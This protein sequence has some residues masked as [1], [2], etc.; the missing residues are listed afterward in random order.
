MSDTTHPD[1]YRVEG[2]GTM[3]ERDVIDRSAKHGARSGERSDEEER[4]EHDDTV[5][6]QT[7]FNPEEGDDVERW[8]E[9]ADRHHERYS[10]TKNSRRQRE[11]VYDAK[12]VASQLEF[13]DYQTEELVRRLTSVDFD[14]H[15]TYTYEAVILA[16]STLVANRDGRWLRRNDDDVGD[17]LA[18]TFEKLR[19]EFDVRRGTIRRLRKRLRP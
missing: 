14:E 3:H 12:L 2:E 7:T 16:L 18:A 17:D 19:R 10:H 15:G 9:L 11:H 6:G 8:K 5:V 1:T 13:T 4:M